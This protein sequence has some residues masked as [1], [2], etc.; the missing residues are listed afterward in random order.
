[1]VLFSSAC[2]H[3]LG[4][5]SSLSIGRMIIPIIIFAQLTTIFVVAFATFLGPF[6]IPPLALPF[7]VA[8]LIF[9]SGMLFYQRFPNPFSI[10]EFP[11]RTSG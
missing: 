11:D 9:F 6:G 2:A 4:F 8:V 3:F 10:V 5:D 7:N 1:M